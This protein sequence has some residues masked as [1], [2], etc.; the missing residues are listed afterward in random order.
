MLN[1]LLLFALIAAGVCYPAAARAEVIVFNAA[2]SA[3]PIG[4]IEVTPFNTALGSL[5]EVRVSITGTMQVTGLTPQNGVNFPGGFIPVPYSYGVEVRQDFDGL[6]SSF[7]DFT[8]PAIFQLQGLATGFPLAFAFAVPFVYTFEFTDIT[9]LI[10]FAI[11]S[12]SPGII[13]PVSVAGTTHAFNDT[14]ALL[15]LIL[16]THVAIPIAIN[17]PPPGIISF[18]AAGV[19]RIEYEYVPTVPRDPNDPGPPVPEPAS[20]TLIAIGVLGRVARRRLV[21]RV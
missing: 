17:G 19:L 7:F 2:F 6:G 14:G 9:D 4:Q 15:N 11:P 3:G 10:G 13:P 12:T 21:R 18:G 5:E 8:T 20:L 16:L 1:R